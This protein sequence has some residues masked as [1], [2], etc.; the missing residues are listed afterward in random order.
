MRSPDH[1]DGVLTAGAPS[2]NRIKGVR[3]NASDMSHQEFDDADDL[4]RGDP[5]E[6]ADRYLDLLAT[7]PDLRLVGGAAAPQE[8]IGV[9]S[10]ALTDCPR[11]SSLRPVPLREIRDA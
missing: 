8:H 7:L 9:I 3:A 1:F 6:R 5:T 11:R 4:D 2:L 10:A